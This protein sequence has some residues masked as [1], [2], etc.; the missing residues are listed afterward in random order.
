MRIERVVI[1]NYRSIRDLAF[2]P[3]SLCAL[4]GENN[5]GKSNI[6][7]ALNLVLG[8]TWPSDRSFTDDDFYQHDR[9]NEILIQ[10]VFDTGVEVERYGKVV[11]VFGFRLTCGQYKRATKNKK[12]GDLKSEFICLNQNGEPIKVPSKPYAKGQESRPYSVNLNVSA[13]LREQFPLVYVDVW[14]DYSSHSPSS[15]WSALNR[16]FRNVNDEFGR[17]VIDVPGAPHPVLRKELYERKVEEL[18]NLLRTQSFLDIE[19]RVRNYALE[20]L[21][22]EPSSDDVRI[23][24]QP[25]DPFNVYRNMEVVITEGGTSHAAS[26]VGAGYQSSLVVA[27]FR[28]YQELQKGNAIIAVEEPEGYLHPHRQRFFYKVLRDIARQGNQVFYTTHSA[29]FVD[30]MHPETVNIVR[31]SKDTGTK[32]SCCPPQQWSPTQREEFKLLR[33]FDPERSELF[34]SK[35]CLLVEGDTEKFL[36]PA[37][38]KQYGIDADAIGLSVVEVGGKSNLP[39]FINVLQHFEIPFVVIHDVDVKEV[40]AKW[41]PERQK[42]QREENEFHEALNSKIESAILDKTRLFTFDPDL[43][44]DCGFNVGKNDKVRRALEFVQGEV[45]EDVRQRLSKPIERL[46]GRKLES[47]VPTDRT[48]EVPVLK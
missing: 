28:A 10:V 35:Y 38:L 42:K 41:S 21:G 13:D 15:R 44:E 23:D 14:R 4:I 6:L 30:V 19:A 5:A 11:K 43:E 45:S 36:F 22:L 18:F 40:D 2:E 26:E 39:I 33:E 7:R 48:E 24:F 17:E 29:N 16:L 20:Q 8:E 32:V 46:L 1:K 25:F 34:F 47:N 27:I 12:A 37:L 9:S 3:A 31:K